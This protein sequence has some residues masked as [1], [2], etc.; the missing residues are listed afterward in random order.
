M[1][2]LY[3]IHDYGDYFNSRQKNI[4][5]AVLSMESETRGI[6]ATGISYVHDNRLQIYKR[7]IPAHKMRYNVPEKVKVIMGH[8]RMTTQG[9]EK[10][11]ENNHPFFGRVKN[12]T[13]SLAHNGI[14]HNDSFLRQSMN[15]PKTNIETD[16]YIAVQLIEKENAVTFDS[17]RKMAETVVGSFVFTVLDKHNNLYFV[18]GDNPICVYHFAD[19]GFYLYASTEEILQSSL[20]RLGIDK[21]YSHR[22]PIDTGDILRIN[23]IGDI[24]KA[25]FQ[26]TEYYHLYYGYY[27]RYDYDWNTVPEKDNKYNDD[28]REYLAILK[29]TAQSYGYTGKDIDD[30]IA[31]GWSL[32]DIEQIIYEDDLY[33]DEIIYER[34]E[35]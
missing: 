25:K 23:R 24:D 20:V 13:F 6:D 28:Y 2:A 5:M 17:L 33:D 1:C 34:M 21:W 19:R 7:P 9:N 26:V 4:I 15:L 31:E 16:S 18:R 22:V 14:L 10:K 35:V 32:V 3:G 30:M 11:N 8:T 27:S 29:Q 12:N